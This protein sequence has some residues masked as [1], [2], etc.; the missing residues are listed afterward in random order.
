MVEKYDSTE[1]YIDMDRKFARAVFDFDFKQAHDIMA[2]GQFKHTKDS[3]ALL[4]I[5]QTMRAVND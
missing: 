1:K 4:N 5:V 3:I 2:D